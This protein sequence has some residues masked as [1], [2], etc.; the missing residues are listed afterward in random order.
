MREY[1][2]F[3]LTLS[4]VYAV[5]APEAALQ[6]TFGSSVGGPVAELVVRNGGLRFASGQTRDR[7]D[8]LPQF[9]AQ[10]R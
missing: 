8:E 5:I 9:G 7:P 6:S 2:R 10:A 1:V 3:S 4:M